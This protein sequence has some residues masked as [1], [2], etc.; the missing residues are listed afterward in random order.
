MYVHCEFHLQVTHHLLTL[1]SASLLHMLL[2]SVGQIKPVG[3]P[4]H[5]QVPWNPSCETLVLIFIWC[6]PIMYACFFTCT[7]FVFWLITNK[8]MAS[9]FYNPNSLK[10]CRF[11]AAQNILLHNSVS[12]S[13]QLKEAIV[14]KRKKE[15]RSGT[16]LCQGKMKTIKHKWGILY[17]KSNQMPHIQSSWVLSYFQT[18]EHVSNKRA[19]KLDAN[20]AAS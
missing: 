9:L 7:V 14:M 12:A 6:V 15:E 19:T 11:I 16:E 1:A 18:E 3:F 2:Y 8:A 4:R 5:P 13:R 17:Q 20:H 10:I